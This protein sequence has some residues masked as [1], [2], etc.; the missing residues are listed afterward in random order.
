VILDAVEGVLIVSPSEAQLSEYEAKYAHHQRRKEQLRKLKELP[1]VTEDGHRVEL[2][3][4]IGKLED[5]EKAID[6]GAEAI[7]L[8]RTE[9]LYMERSG[10]PS[11]EEQFTI[12]K[13]VLEKM[14]GKPV[15]IRTLDIGGDKELPYMELPKESNPFLGQ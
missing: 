12:Y 9:F 5:L 6:N 1:T 4:N 8:F 13:H 2:A 11:E 7:G 14:G 3:A 10:F 15:V